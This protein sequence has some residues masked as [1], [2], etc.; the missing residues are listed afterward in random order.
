MASG[1]YRFLKLYRTALIESAGSH[2]VVLDPVR[3]EVFAKERT[4]EVLAQTSPLVMPTGQATNILESKAF[5][6]PA[7]NS[8]IEFVA[9]V[10][11]PS[12]ARELCE[13]QIDRAVALLSAILTPDLFAHEVWRG[14][15]TDGV[16]LAADAW[17]KLVA[18]IS[19]SG[20][21]IREHADRFRRALRK[22][23]DLDRRF[24]L[25]SKLFARAIS[26][27]PS[28]EKFLWLW[29]VLEVFPMRDTSNIAP[30]SDLLSRIISKPAVDL[31]AKLQIGQL[32]G[33]RSAL[34]HDGRLPIELKD[35]G[36]VL[37]KLEA[38]GLVIIRFAGGMPYQGELNQY[39]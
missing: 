2:V 14:W 15:I 9:R 3:I 1:F 18:P 35:L 21:A 27:R 26:M 24:T 8:Y 17:L 12:G 38:I 7:A 10:K 33:Y 34:V 4:Y 30:I 6:V 11:D 13:N 20:D 23:S 16:L 36:S 25:M 5:T 19:I 31:K 32:F 29:T 28:E 22:D 37:G 39:L